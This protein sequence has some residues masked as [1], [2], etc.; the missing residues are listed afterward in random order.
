MRTS[1]E[2]GAGG[3][4]TNHGRGDRVEPARSQDE[5]AEAPGE[6]AGP[7]TDAETAEVTD[8]ES[9][10]SAP[11]AEDERAA[12][13]P[14][15][16]EAEPAG[17][18]ARPK[19]SRPA[20]VAGR[21]RHGQVKTE[22]WARTPPAQVVR[23]AVQAGVLVPLL[24]FISPFNV[25]G[26]RNLSDLK[27]P[28]VFVANHQSH[29]D[30]PICLAAL[31]AR[32][33]RRLVIAA[34]ADYFYSSPVKGMAASLALGTVPFVRQ[35][36][37]SRE[38]LQML[39][40]LIGKGWSVLIFPSGTRGKAGPFKKGF[41]YLA[42][43]TQVPVVPVYLHGLERVMPK[44]SFVPLPGGVVVGIGPPIPPGKDYNDLVKRAEAAVAQAGALVERLGGT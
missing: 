18:A 24:R 3:D 19:P 17:T 41:A 7:A 25:I 34:A 21:G 20:R 35:G 11:D 29:F 28:A 23:G 9:A 27:G 22:G 37:S 26:R 42:I 43:D 38:S 32:V 1:G 44:G 16:S 14:P 12:S 13:A 15:A 40:E 2:G 10:G 31:G 5:Q 33:R 8:Q 39:K 4:V 30:A 36:G 6:A